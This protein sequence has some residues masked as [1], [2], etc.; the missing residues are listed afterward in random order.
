MERSDY[1][2]KAIISGLVGGLSAVVVT[3]LTYKINLKSKF[4]D[5]EWLI[6]IIR[7]GLIGI[8]TF[9]ILHFVL[10]Y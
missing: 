4:S 7:A 6:V 5:K 1:N 3:Y 10:D 9:L 2:L 8:I